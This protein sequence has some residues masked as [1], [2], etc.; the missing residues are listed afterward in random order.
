M[1]RGVIVMIRRTIF[2]ILI[3]FIVF[4]LPGVQ[5]LA[6]SDE[7]ILDEIL[8]EIE[9]E[10][11]AADNDNGTGD[12]SEDETADYQKHD[13]PEYNPDASCAIFIYMCGSNLESNHGFAGINIEELLEADIPES[14][15][16]I[17]E[18]GGAKQWWSDPQIAN[19]KLQRYTVQ[20]KQLVLEEELPNASMGDEYVFEDFLKWGTR[21]YPAD[22]NIL[23]L[24]DHGGSSANGVCYDENYGFDCL[25]RSELKEALDEAQL[26]QP[27]DVI[28]FD[29]CYMGSLGTASLVKDYAHYM[30]ASQKIVPGAGMDYKTL[31]ESFARNDDE[32]L[33]RILCDSFMEKCRETGQDLTAQLTFYDLAET[34]ALIR[35]FN[36]ACGSIRRFNDLTGF[37]FEIFSSALK[38]HIADSPKDVNAI[39]FQH[40]VDDLY[41]LD[42]IHRAELIRKREDSLISYQV[43][44]VGADCTGISIY[45]PL[46]YNK[47][48]L[49]EYLE[50]GPV[51]NYCGLLNDIYSNLPEETISFENPGCIAEDGSFE[52]KISDTSRFYL[53]GVIG[54]IWRESEYIPGKYEL[55][56]DGEVETYDTDLGRLFANLTLN[57]TFDGQV[58]ALDGHPILLGVTSRLTMITYSAPIRVNGEDTFYT[59]ICVKRRGR[60]IKVIT[61]LGNSTDENGLASR[62]IRRLEEGDIVSTYSA[63]DENGEKLT[64]GE[65]FIIGEDGG[66]LELIPLPEG[67]YRYQ[68]IATD[69]IGNSVGSDYCIFE[70]TQEN[71]VRNAQ[72]KEIV[73]NEETK[74][75]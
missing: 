37:S 59:F 62:E 63:R 69:I 65:E 8:T 30:T 51:R 71:G 73:V 61:L 28:I 52:A 2:H 49:E 17:I 31:A 72:M 53:R 16:V 60:Q 11:I 21:N 64:E 7:S 6:D 50:T 34:D 44:G 5:V 70:I 20:N 22:R 27:F 26:P 9:A 68:F 54:R 55:L 75:N 19:D 25:T 56:M 3:L 45:Y 39:D 24:W 35:A 47:K 33:G 57:S 46:T 67:R 14:T 15:N 13:K 10:I 38:A 41:R 32:T 40:F 48:Q 23:V 29:T 74:I 43:C 18:T 66:K 58:A 42:L 36:L 4:T 12:F 1:S